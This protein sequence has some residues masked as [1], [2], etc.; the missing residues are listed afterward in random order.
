MKTTLKNKM[1]ITALMLALV[2]AP[3]LAADPADT[4]EPA[5]VDKSIEAFM[6]IL[7]F[8]M[9]VVED[10]IAYCEDQAAK[11]AADGDFK[12]AELW[13][14]TAH[15]LEEILE[16]ME[17]QYAKLRDQANAAK[18][19]SSTIKA[20][21]QKYPDTPDQNGDKSNESKKVQELKERYNKLDQA[22]KT[23]TASYVKATG[24]KVVDKKL[25]WTLEKAV[26]G[27]EAELNKIAAELA[28]I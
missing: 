25:V 20:Q 11:F 19:V 26:E 4:Q 15:N 7:R 9:G 6:E 22:L 12:Q 18:S 14:Q 8:Q 2:A 1:M 23:A 27:L 17:K 5:K 28:A 24:A 3:A 13:K 21:E 16:D 10:E